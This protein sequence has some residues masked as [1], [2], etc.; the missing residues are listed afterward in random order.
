MS[1][2]IFIGGCGFSIPLEGS[3]ITFFELIIGCPG[4]LSEHLMPPRGVEHWLVQ[5]ANLHKVFFRR[6]AWHINSAHAP[7]NRDHGGLLPDAYLHLVRKKAA[8]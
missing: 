6:K 3:I 8:N 2:N 5:P 7:L 4:M 1:R